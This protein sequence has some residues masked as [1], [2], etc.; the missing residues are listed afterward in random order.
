MRIQNEPGAYGVL[1]GLLVFLLGLVVNASCAC[2]PRLSVQ[3]V[4]D[5]YDAAVKIEATCVVPVGAGSFTIGGWYG[6][7]VIVDRRRVLTAAHVA[8]GD[9]KQLC[10]FVITD[11]AG[12]RRLADPLVVNKTLDLASMKLQD[13]ATDFTA[14][15]VSFGT[16]PL[17]GSTVCAA[18][19]FPR[20]AH[21]C[22]EVEPYDDA[23]GDIVV[24]VIVEHGNSG[25]ALY[26][27]AGQLVGVL[28]HLVFCANGQWCAG[29]AA[30]L[31]G[32]IKELLP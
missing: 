2:G 7:G 21:V 32:H 14:P 30:S 23:P 26:D 9:A 8:S 28:T 27:D 6:S 3:Q 29:K 31:Q 12:V 10:S 13:S 25:G 20:P 15:P 11:S 18:P 1:A 5:E 22:G 17:L 24:D 16:K 4:H 19:A